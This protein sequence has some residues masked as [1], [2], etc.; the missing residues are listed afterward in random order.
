MEAYV[1]SQKIL[2][3]VRNNR[4]IKDDSGER[5]QRSRS[6]NSEKAK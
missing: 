1:K 5:K 2:N 4:L 3:I 6:N